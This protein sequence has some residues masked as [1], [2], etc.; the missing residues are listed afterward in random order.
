M[1]NK[2]TIPPKNMLDIVNNRLSDLSHE[3]EAIRF[4]VQAINSKLIRLFHEVNLK[5]QVSQKGKSDN[6]S[7]TTDCFNGQ[8]SLRND[9]DTC[10]YL[11]FVKNRCKRKRSPS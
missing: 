6:S 11:E 3:M 5:P 8:C 1:I 9:N 2:R 7:F 10:E 4:K